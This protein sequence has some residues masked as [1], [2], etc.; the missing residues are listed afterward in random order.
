MMVTF[1]YKRTGPVIVTMICGLLLFAEYW[2]NFA[3]LKPVGDA[4]RTSGVT[5]FGYAL[6]V[7]TLS[8]V[9][10]QGGHVKQRK[11]P[12]A[13]YSAWMLIVMMIFIVTGIATSSTSTQYQLVFNTIYVPASTAL[14]GLHG[15]WITSACY[16]AYR[17][18][19]AEALALFLVGIL[20][21]LG[22]APWGP[23]ISSDFVNVSNWLMDF[24]NKPA[25]T[26]IL[27]GVGLGTVMIG[28]R[29]ILGFEKSYL[30]A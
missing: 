3:G 16:R 8:L 2:I 6:I 19:S 12:Q 1:D 14:W 22:V 9:R 17:V 10:W 29:T 25:M 28:L 30:G 7:G 11:M 20:V 13:A 5:I 23:L 15:F 21:L 26:A 24:V 27:I 18:R 4:I